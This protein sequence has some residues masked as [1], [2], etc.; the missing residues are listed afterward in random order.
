MG[1][2]QSWDPIHSPINNE[3][4]SRRSDFS[5]IACILYIAAA[6][7]PAEELLNVPIMS[8]E[9]HPQIEG[10]KYFMPSTRILFRT[11]HYL[12]CK[13]QSYKNKLFTLVPILCRWQS[14]KTNYACSNHM[15]KGELHVPIVH[16]RMRFQNMKCPFAAFL[17][18]SICLVS[19]FT[20]KLC[21]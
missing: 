1:G 13:W 3:G 14:Y 17:E 5:I 18:N 21:L 9:T 6:E 2:R 19:T 20:K 15:L 7:H 8:K 10:G 12:L 11:N 16:T 4:I